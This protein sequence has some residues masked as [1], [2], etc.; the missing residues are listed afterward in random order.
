MTDEE[1]RTWLSREVAS[2]D[3]SESQ[4]AD[5][6]WQ[7]ALFDSEFGEADSPARQA[8]RLKIVGYVAELRRVDT[9][10][11][12]LLDDA[13]RAFPG[14]MIYFEPIGFDLF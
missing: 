1:F 12:R 11:H 3:M 13:K 6:L 2:G 10:I 5:L 7:K 9:D 14:R 4:M 8:Y